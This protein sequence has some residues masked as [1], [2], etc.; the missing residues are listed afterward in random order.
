MTVSGLTL[1]LHKILSWDNIETPQSF[2][3]KG[4]LTS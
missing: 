4:F 3:V 2:D 1:N